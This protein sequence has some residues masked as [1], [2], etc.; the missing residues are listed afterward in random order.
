MIACANS[1]GRSLQYIAAT[2]T[3]APLA[4]TGAPTGNTGTV[5]TDER[6]VLAIGTY[7]YPRR[8]AWGSR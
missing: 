2:P 3:V 5:V 4:I 6:H 7:N 8:V 1:D